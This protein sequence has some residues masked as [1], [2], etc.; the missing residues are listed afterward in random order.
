MKGKDKKNLCRLY[1]AAMSLS[2]AATCFVLPAAAQEPVETEAPAAAVDLYP[3]PQSVVYDSTEGMSLEGPVDLVVHGTVTET[4]LE[5][6][7]TILEEEGIEYQQVEAASPDHAQILISSD[8]AHCDVCSGIADAALAEA[9]GYILYTD[10]D[11]NTKGE[12]RIIGADQAG[13][14]NGIMSLDQLL[15]QKNEAGKYAEVL[16][17]DYPD[18]KLRGFVEGFYGYTWSFEN[19]C[20]VIEQA[21]KYKINEYIY[22]PKDDPYHKDKWRE[23]YPEKE[24]EQIRTLVQT[25]NDNHV[26]FVW[27]AHPGNGYNY[28][29]D[30]D[31][32]TLTAKIE[33]LYSLGVRRFG[34]SY[35]DLSGSANGANQAALI[36]RVEEYLYDKYGD[37]GSMFTVGQRYTDGWG[38]DWNT[39][40]KPY[41]NGLNDDVIVMWTGKN[42]GGNCDADS[43]NGPKNRVGYEQ[44]LAF[45]FNYP[46]NDMAFGRILMGA[47]DNVDPELESLRGFFMNPMN[48]AQASKVAIYQGADY[49][50]NIHDYESDRS[51]NRAIKEVLPEHAAALKRYADNTSYHAYEDLSHD[52]SMEMKPYFEEL[53]AAIAAKNGVAEK[54]AALKAKFVEMQSDADELLGMND[55]L[56]LAE[57]SEHLQAYKNLGEAGE[58]AMEGFEAALAGN[59]SGMQKAVSAMNAKVTEANTH[60]IPALNR[61]N[62]SY[63]VQAEVCTKVIR[64]YLKNAA[65]RMALVLKAAL[66][67][68]VESRIISSDAAATGTAGLVSGNYQGTVS[69]VLSKGGYAGFAAD[70]AVKV[71]AINVEGADGLR[72]EYSLNGADWNVYTGEEG[73]IDVAYVRVVN[74]GAA[75]VT[76]DNAVITAVV[77]Y[78][79]VNMTASTD[80][81]TY[82]SYYISN[83]VD[84]NF[85]TRYY[86][87]DGTAVG[88]YVQV[89]LNNTVPLY[90]VNIWF[91]GNPKGADH[92]S[93]AFQGTDLEVS[94][95]GVSWTKI[96]ETYVA[97]NSEQYKTVT[98]NNTTMSNMTWD[99]QGTMA[100]YLRFTST[101]SYGN[102]VQVYEIQVNNNSPEAGDDEV[103]LGET[104]TDGVT[105][106]LYDQDV[107]T[108]FEVEAPAE[109]DYVIYNMSTVTSVKELLLIQDENKI[110]NAKVSVQA[111]N[112]TWSEARSVDEWKE[113]GVFSE[114]S[115]TFPVN[116]LIR[117]VRLDFEPGTPVSIS[118]IVV[119]PT[120]TLLDGAITAPGE[121]PVV[122]EANK[123]LLSLAIAEAERLDNEETLAGIN[124][125]VVNNFHT[126][127][128][129][130][131]AV[132]ADKSA[133]QAQVYAAWTKLV[134]AIH[135][136]D[137]RAD[138]TELQ[139]LID[140]CETLNPDDFA[141][142]DA[143]TEFLAA[144]EYA[145]EVNDDPAALTDQSIQA[146]IDRLNAAREALLAEQTLDTTLL[147]FLLA[148]TEDVDEAL[149]TASTLEVLH[150]AQEAARAV[151]AD[152]I[153]QIRID[154]AVSTL[155][156][157]W[158]NLRLTASEELLKQLSEVSAAIAAFSMDDMPVALQ[159][160]TYAVLNSYNAFLNAPEQSQ[161]DGQKLL[162]AMNS[163]LSD[164]ND[165]KASLDK[166]AAD[167]KEDLNKPAADKEDLNK[168]AA[169]KNTAGTSQ[170]A[171]PA[172]SKSVKT[173]AGMGFAGAAL[174][175]LSA[176][177][178][179]AA[180]KRRNRK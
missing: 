39:Y 143:K 66:A 8:D 112:G 72:V 144:L 40:L 117:A 159:S 16:V 104:N 20:S 2:M 28:D 177:G 57:L 75:G 59:A 165:A 42:T 29:T 139:S 10:D 22:A 73:N 126:A 129:E 180:L 160:R 128:A 60:K 46:V 145:K 78:S 133:T 26:E 82:Q 93:D 110:S 91:G 120:E 83:A 148:Q 68:E 135:M 84:G 35:D 155:H 63:M 173:A 61:N 168:P 36:N 156:D 58:L 27:C 97:E 48:Q 7:K 109:G 141:D 130:A 43:F 153:S 12:I 31:Y 38:A 92:G 90:D 14:W 89:D 100:R 175:G 95:D 137:F 98:V 169:D 30:D 1:S 94:A 122:E 70:K 64:P 37:V 171:A 178:V 80:M 76:L 127:L 44:E 164:L 132:Q 18:I 115:Q 71:S 54:V 85:N 88:N 53:D 45:W 136:L 52:E 25:C 99:A 74:D 119:R 167:G 102:W 11:E 157:A 166:P 121:A 118:E 174:S 34:L 170:S 163:V 50:W 162:D 41:L 5:R 138:K 111:L 131:K 105:R 146:A 69:A 24:A 62:G 65:D 33:Q 56:L 107:D 147:E 86:S 19:R 55:A 154:N 32:N 4:S 140:V 151:L 103:V 108:V 158:L 49:S 3:E 152:P 179:L 123:M 9:Q 47:L 116:A 87:A 17:A 21:S 172:T 106:N 23:L 161:E 6:V 51:W 77:V 96:G 101:V 125:L 114:A 67:P 142:S 79:D 124:E 176:L 15:D 149:Y 113:I 13:V 81:S 150:Q 134:N